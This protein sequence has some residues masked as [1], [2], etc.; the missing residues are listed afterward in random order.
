[1]GPRAQVMVRDP[2]ESKPNEETKVSQPVKDGEGKT[3]G[4]L[5]EH[6]GNDNATINQ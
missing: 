6:E 5:D 3:Q 2:T 4:G 1:M